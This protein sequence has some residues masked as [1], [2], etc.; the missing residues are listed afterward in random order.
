MIQNPDPEFT[1]KAM[2]NNI[3]LLDKYINNLVPKYSYPKNTL[4]QIPE[5]LD[6]DSIKP[7]I[8]N[9]YKY[10]KKYKNT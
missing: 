7:K 4:E 5:Y 8:N 1:V 10:F 3:I 9:V 2:N 6:I